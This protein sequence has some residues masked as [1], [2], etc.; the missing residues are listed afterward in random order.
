MSLPGS[1]DP[2]HVTTRRKS[3]L[4]DGPTVKLHPNSRDGQLVPRARQL[5]NGDPPVMDLHTTVEVE[6]GVAP[7]RHL[8]LL[9]M[10][11]LNAVVMGLEFCAS[12]AFTYIPPMLLKA[13][14]QEKYM[15]I[16]LGIGPLLG[17]LFVPVIGQASDHCRSKYG[18][19]RPY[20][21]LLGMLLVVS[22]I[23]IPY[24]ELFGIYAMGGTGSKHLGVTLLIVGSV[25]LDFT[26][27]ACLT[28]CEA[29]L[30]DASMNT[31]QKDRCFTIYSLMV[32]IG[33]CVGYLIGALD[34]NS[35]SVGIFFGSQEKSAFTI[36]IVLF[37]LTLFATLAVADEKPLDQIH[38]EEK[39][40]KLTQLTTVDQLKL[41]STFK[42]ASPDP[43][44]ETDSDPGAQE[45]LLYNGDV[46]TGSSGSIFRHWQWN[47]PLTRVTFT[48]LRGL[49]H[50]LGL[51]L[52]SI[53]PQSIKALVH[54]PFVL[55]RLA[56][57]NFFSWTAVMGFNLFFT[58]YVGQAIYG[59]NPNAPEESHERALYDEGVRMGSWGLLL[60][61]VVS[62]AYAGL[63]DRV[64]DRYGF[65]QMYFFGMLTFTM[66]LSLLVFT[67]HF[68]LVNLVAMLTGIGFATVTTIPF[69]LIMQY[70]DDKQ[71]RPFQCGSMV[72]PKKYHK[73]SNIRHTKSENLGDCRLVLQLCL[74]N[75]L[76]PGVKLGMKM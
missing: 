76:K 17:F 36:L 11:L 4:P 58:D 6:P 68:I 23:V 15:S 33:G 18:R 43:G 16:L 75:P 5:S 63:V 37:V 49:L 34:W 2:P 31:N 62:A 45:G 53:L 8:S 57:A 40:L 70:H 52:Y 9:Q 41:E 71:V 61:C 26:S 3:L 65:K 22:L 24:G 35:S 47:V 67:R 60:H 30:S 74:A 38:A 50:L 54:I 25:M 19:R 28:P 20:I 21:L 42:V 10:L 32:S 56:I 44:Y 46:P 27:Q 59:G 72:Y 29:L 73:I 69:M 7:R 48:T 39:K 13:G 55:R 14:I 51:R 66:A 1:I 64:V 12:A